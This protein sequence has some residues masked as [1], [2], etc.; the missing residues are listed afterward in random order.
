MAGGWLLLAGIETALKLLEDQSMEA[1]SRLRVN[2]KWR[3]ILGLLLCLLI[4]TIAFDDVLMS[5]ARLS[6]QTYIASRRLSRALDGARSV[7]FVEYSER[8][9]DRLR[10]TGDV[11]R[12]AQLRR[13][14]TYWLMPS[15]PK[16]GLC[17]N[18]HHRVEIVKADGSLL[19]FAVCFQCNGFQLDDPPWSNLFVLPDPWNESLARLFNSMKMAPFNFPDP[20]DTSE[21]REKAKTTIKGDNSTAENGVT[22]ER[23]GR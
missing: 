9:G 13:A 20:M 22:L 23:G 12:I 21:R 16:P 8:G 1:K 17:F 2:K 18:P 14:T 19:Q 3:L 6:V 10:V 7:Q 4:A 5:V 11:E 15:R